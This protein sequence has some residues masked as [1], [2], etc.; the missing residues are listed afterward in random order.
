MAQWVRRP[1]TD[2]GESIQI[3]WRMDGRWQ[4]ASFTDPRLAA[5]FRTAVELAG[6]QWPAGWLKRE[7]WTPGQEGAASPVPDLESV[8]GPVIVHQEP[9][10]GSRSGRRDHGWV[11]G[12]ENGQ[13]IRCLRGRSWWEGRAT[14]I[15]ILDI[16]GVI[17]FVRCSGSPIRPLFVI[18]NGLIRVLLSISLMDHAD[19]R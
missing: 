14:F 19:L 3:K 10:Q 11:G 9:Q 8:A 17:Q 13:L 1:R 15:G 18:A 5:E 16:V 12:H 4:S 2:G 6:H 7:G